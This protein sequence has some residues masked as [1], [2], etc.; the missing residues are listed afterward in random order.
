MAKIVRSIKAYFKWFIL[1]ATLFFL[2]KTFR[3]NWQNVST[4]KI[5]TQGWLILTLALIVTFL[6]HIWSGLVWA[7]LLRSLKQPVTTRWSLQLYLITNIAKYLPGNVGHFYGRISAIYKAGGSLSVAS[8]SVLLEPLLMA[9]AAFLITVLASSIGLIKMGGYPWLWQVN[10]IIFPLVLIGIHPKVLNPSL[11][12]ISRLK[13]KEKSS[14]VEIEEYPAI[15]LLGEIGFLLLRGTG[16][17]LTWMALIPLDL[18]QIPT[19]FSAFS[20]AW[21]MGLIVPGAPGG[22]GIFEA[23]A[24][25]L[26]SQQNLPKGIIL[27][28]IAL[29]RVISILAEAIAAGLAWLSQKSDRMAQS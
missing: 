7:R 22:I 9:A 13:N 1:G 18:S 15:Y 2:I 29:F 24:I 10:L 12:F 23:I 21:L 27:S 25:A 17:I 11:Q 16:F 6:A 8:L 14:T 19:L 4:V 5:E 3:D 26:L 20:F 28:A